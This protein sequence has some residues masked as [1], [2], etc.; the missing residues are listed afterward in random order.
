[1]LRKKIEEGK[2]TEVGAG[3]RS[4]CIAEKE[5]QKRHRMATLNKDEMVTDSQLWVLVYS[6]RQAMQKVHQAVGFL[7]SLLQLEWGG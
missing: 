6:D 5:S 1:M 3:V 7:G 2:N 4:V